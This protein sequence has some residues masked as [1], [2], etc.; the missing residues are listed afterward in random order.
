VSVDTVYDRLL[1]AIYREEH[2][3]LLDDPG[4]GGEASGRGFDLGAFRDAVA[5]RTS[6]FLE[7]E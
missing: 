5:Q 2:D 3:W 1:A 7:P 4:G 6:E